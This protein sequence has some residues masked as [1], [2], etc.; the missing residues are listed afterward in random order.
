[1]VHAEVACI[2]N[3]CFWSFCIIPSVQLA[4]AA[5]AAMKRHRGSAP[6]ALQQLKRQGFI[7]PGSPQDSWTYVKQ[8]VVGLE[9]SEALACESE[10]RQL[11]MAGLCML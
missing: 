7:T 6:I 1:M 5:K 4:M 3:T 8:H 11:Q 2:K 9:R 10:A